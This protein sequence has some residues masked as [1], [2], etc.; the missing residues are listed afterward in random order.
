MKNKTILILFMLFYLLISS[1]NIAF[2]QSSF[3]TSTLIPQTRM[4]GLSTVHKYTIFCQALYTYRMDVI[5]RL[6]LS[7][8]KEKLGN[9][10]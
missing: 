4:G 1:V 6:P 9:L 10:G 3:Q 2:S 8:I 7:Q 5:K